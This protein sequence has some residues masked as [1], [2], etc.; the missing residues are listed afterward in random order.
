MVEIC[1][2]LPH[3]WLLWYCDQPQPI[4][5]EN[6][7]PINSLRT[8]QEVGR[9]G[10]LCSGPTAESLQVFPNQ[11]S[12]EK[13]PIW[14]FCVPQYYTLFGG[15]WIVLNNLPSLPFVLPFTVELLKSQH[16]PELWVVDSYSSTI[17]TLVLVS[18][19]K[20]PFD[21]WFISVRD[22]TCTP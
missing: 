16:P 8:S 20:Y 21:S 5:L 22:G 2:V 10:P 4:Q 13:L 18:N 9:R 7:K 1:V 12:Q 6:A 11:T 19:N 15:P 17:V 14:R 3:L